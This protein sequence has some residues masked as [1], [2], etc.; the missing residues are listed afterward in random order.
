MVPFRYFTHTTSKTRY[1]K[2]SFSHTAHGDE[3]SGSVTDP[4]LW[5]LS[6]SRNTRHRT[7]EELIR[8]M[9]MSSGSSGL[10]LRSRFLPGGFFQ[11]TIKTPPTLVPLLPKVHDELTKSGRAPYS[12]RI[13]PSGSTAL[14]SID[15]AEEKGYERLPSL[16]ESVA[17]HLCLPTAIG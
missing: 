11:G 17:T 12:S 14:T 7:N 8:I 1:G 3:L 4:T 13:R 15:C 16:D 2:N 5:P 9:S 10:C 6:S